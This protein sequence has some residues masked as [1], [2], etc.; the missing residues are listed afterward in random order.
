[1]AAGI[2]DRIWT[3]QD[4]FSYKGASH[5]AYGKRVMRDAFGSRFSDILTT[6]VNYGSGRPARIDGTIDSHIA[7]E[8]E[9]RVFKQIR[10]ALLDL[11]CHRYPKKLLLLMPAAGQIGPTAAK[12]CEFIF[13]KFLQP[14]DYCVIVLSGCGSLQC[15]DSDISLVR[16]EVEKWLSPR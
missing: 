7:V 16:M 5:D 12:Q 3:I 6:E 9:S 8:I 14:G 1:M 4:L 15:L 11:L 13:A 2:A 10:G